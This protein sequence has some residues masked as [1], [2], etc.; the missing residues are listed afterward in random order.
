MNLDENSVFGARGHSNTLL[1]GQAD[2]AITRTVTK[3]ISNSEIDIGSPK[4]A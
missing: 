4:S 2:G 3:M 1:P